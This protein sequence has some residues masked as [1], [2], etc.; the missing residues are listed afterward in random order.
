MTPRVGLRA[1]NRALLDRQLLLQRSS[2]TAFE[3]IEHLVGMQAQEPNAPYV[4]LWTRIDGFDPDELVALLETRAAVRLA[5]MRGTLHLVTTRDALWMRAVVQPVLE[6]AFFVG[7]PFGR[8]L[9]GLRL[10]PVLRMGRLLV[11]EQPRTTAEIGRLLG[12]RWPDWDPEALGYA[13]RY[14]LPLVQVPPRGIWGVGG[15]ARNTTLEVWVGQ[16]MVSSPTVSDLVIRYLA[17]FGPASV[18]DLQY[19]SGLTKLNEVVDALRGRLREQ[20]DENDV[21]LFDVDDAPRPSADQPAPVRFLPEFDNVL[22]AHHDR[23][24]I[25]AEDDRGT[26]VSRGGVGRPTVLIGGFARASW[27]VQRAGDRAT[28][29]VEPYGRLRRT[30]RADIEEEAASLLAF[31]AADLDDHDVIVEMPA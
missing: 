20:R 30:D 27:R 14:L 26:F 17:A 2:S 22:L 28:L 1:L 15:A 16:E 18:K 10:D 9:D 31:V 19:W 4:G 23:S 8:R 5:L 13:A 29:M 6:R 24:R 21:E 12:A 25:I 11:D 3:V 7:S